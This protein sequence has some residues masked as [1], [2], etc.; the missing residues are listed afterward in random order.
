MAVFET[1]L[2]STSDTA[3]M[4]EDGIGGRD[5]LVIMSLWKHH[6]QCQ[7]RVRFVTSPGVSRTGSVQVRPP[8]PRLRNGPVP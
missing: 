1:W 8:Q 4:G 5:F 3:A 2:D 6:D 7:G